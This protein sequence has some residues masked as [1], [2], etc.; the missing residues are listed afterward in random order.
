MSTMDWCV[1]IGDE[2]AFKSR[3]SQNAHP[4]EPA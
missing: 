3:R 1:V 4:D 2:A